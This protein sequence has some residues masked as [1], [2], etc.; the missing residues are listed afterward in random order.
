MKPAVQYVRASM[1]LQSCSLEQQGLANAAYA[2][3]RGFEIL[4][5]YCD[6]GISGLTLRARHG[7]Q[8]L[9]ADALSPTRRFEAILVYDVSRWGRFQDIDE[10]A[11]Y[12][13]LCRQ[14]GVAVHYCAEPFDNEGAPEAN[15]IKQVKRAMAAEFSRAQSERVALARRHIVTKGFTVSR[16]PFGLRRQAVDQ[17]RRPVAL[18][19]AGETKASHAYH[20]VFTLGPADEVA[21]VRAI[22]RL[23]V[24]TGLSVRAIAA[25]LNQKGAPSLSGAG[26]DA[27]QVRR[28]LRR[29]AYAGTYVHGR[30]R[31]QLGAARKAPP[32]E[33]QRVEGAI[34][35]IVDLALFDQAKRL[36]DGRRR[37]TDDELLDDLRALLAQVG[38][39]TCSLV[40]DWPYSAHSDTYKRRFGSLDEA[41]RRIGYRN[42]RGR[43]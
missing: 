31:Y 13:F 30:V 25:D 3:V 35:A 39:I 32:E 37:R 8:R 11:H 24:L 14:A 26:W 6:D 33:W 18:L 22:F 17:Q 36:L 23:Y 34:P 4:D 28:I 15:L 10:G 42:T 7:L 20:V 21:T 27:A 1:G 9:L 38:Q 19:K 40:D 5:T 41:C 2:T 43:S 29:E 12:E 16:P